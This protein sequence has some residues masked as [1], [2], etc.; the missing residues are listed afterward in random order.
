MM[1]PLQFNNPVA[2]SSCNRPPLQIAFMTLF[3][4]LAA[5]FYGLAINYKRL[6]YRAAFFKTLVA[7]AIVVPGS[8]LLFLSLPGT[9]YDRLFPV[10][11]AICAGC[12]AAVLQKARLGNAFN[13]GAKRQ[14]VLSQVL[15]IGLS[16][17][18]LL[19]LLAVLVAINTNKA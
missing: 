12:L 7:G 1:L 11:S 9:P 18:L 13:A 3:G 4:T 2:L 8:I 14:T 10:V 19:P 16:L 17:L 6:S 15:V 5:G